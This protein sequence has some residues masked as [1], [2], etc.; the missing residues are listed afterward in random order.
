MQQMSYLTSVWD[1]NRS[2]NTVGVTP[3]SRLAPT[4]KGT[5][6]ESLPTSSRP[7]VWYK[8]RSYME[9]VLPVTAVRLHL[10]DSGHLKDLPFSTF[11]YPLLFSH[12]LLLCRAMNQPLA[13]HLCL[14]P[15]P[16]KLCLPPRS[17][18]FFFLFFL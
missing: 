3:A 6:M 2:G 15:T 18:R 13:P 9:S 16:R 12:L 5:N 14:L 1:P 11:K 17:G 4:R 10:T 8:C 7:T